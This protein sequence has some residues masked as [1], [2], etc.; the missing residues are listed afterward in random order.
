MSKIL[1]YNQYTKSEK[2]AEELINLIIT[3]IIN[4]SINNKHI[5]KILKDF[6][7]DLKFNIGLV[8]KFGSGIN[9]MFPIVHNLI[10]NGN[11]NI[12]LTN[13]NIALLCIAAVTVIY[14]EE[15]G[16]KEK[17]TTKVNCP[18]CNDKNKSCNT[19]NG[20]GKV[21]ITVSKQDAKNILEELKLRGIGNGIVKKV[22]KCFKSITNLLKVIF[23]NTPFVISSFIEMFAYTSI[24]IPSMSAI[25]SMVNN[26]N[27][28]IDSLPSNLM[29]IG[30]GVGSFF[31]KS[32]FDYIINKL[33]NKF[34][35]KI[36]PDIEVPTVVRH[37]DI[38]DG[39]SSMGDTT[40]IK[41]Q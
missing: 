5:N 37:Y 6:Q 26:Y 30:I 24:L 32:G 11:L 17:I 19:C 7:R 33:R 25:S 20:S 36:N 29:S 9:A 16:N 23:K 13:E 10:K 41:E 8:F 18:D 35:L 38:K 1:R 2:Q 3:P 39:E 31:A 22:V 27:I 4:E 34:K 12:D 21:N 40:L 28:D 15:S 14:L